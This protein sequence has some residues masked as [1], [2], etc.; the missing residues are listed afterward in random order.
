MERGTAVA[1][2]RDGMYLAVGSAT[3]NIGIWEAASG[4]LL[5]TWPAHYKVHMPQL[6]ACA[7]AATTAFT[8]LQRNTLWCLVA[9][10]K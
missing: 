5:T 10:H 7:A 1:A 4:Q 8:R 3:G 9:L 6:V 2:T